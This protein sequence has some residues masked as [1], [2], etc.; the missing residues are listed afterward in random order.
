MAGVQAGPA[1]GHA[2]KLRQK[3]KQSLGV[4]RG[5][6]RGAEEH[7]RGGRARLPKAPSDDGCARVGVRVHV[8]KPV[9][10]P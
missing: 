2:P 3:D 1:C 10:V 9:R 5:S 4:T 7:R 8:C 6:H